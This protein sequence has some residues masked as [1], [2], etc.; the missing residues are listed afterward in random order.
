V[1]VLYA[2]AGV[3]DISPRRSIHLFGYPHVDRFSIAINDPLLSSALYLSD[4]RSP[5]LFVANDIIFVGKASA[6]RVRQRI[7]EASGVPVENILVSA[8]HTHS[9]PSTVDYA[10]LAEDACVGRV[11]PAYLALFEDG[12]VRAALAAFHSAQPA[13]VGLA[14][15][16][17][18]GVGTNRRSIAGP[19][20][21]QVPVLVARTLA[22]G[23]PI[24]AMAV[25]SMHPTV[26]REDSLVVS[27]D[28]PAMARRYLQQNLLGPDCPIVYHT[29]PAGNQSPRYVCRDHSVAETG[30]LGEILG[31]SIA[32]AIGRIE[33]RSDLTLGAHRVLIELPRR[34]FPPAEAARVKLEKAVA[35]LEGLR[36]SG[37]PAQDIR[38]AEVDWFGAEETLRLAAIAHQGGLEEAYAACMP[39]E[40]QALRVGPWRFVGWPGEVFVEY[41]LAVKAQ[42]PDTYIISLANGELQGYI[43]T[44]EAAQ[45][46]GYEASNAV[47][48]PEAGWALVRAT[49]DPANGLLA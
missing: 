1:E 47:F 27:G 20:D 37:A 14:I 42:A 17:G 46:G 19:A 10:S 35:R 18:A 39:A 24:A 34:E 26:L 22:G 49:L 8:T 36:R 32:E 28:F 4:G 12:I 5:L 33:Y 48:A 6:A 21:R 23:K 44:A 43:T 45:E 15:A 2:G 7:A 16:D 25:T 31:R 41:S 38:A 11:D 30:R 9:G 3:A 40:I 13:E 29:G